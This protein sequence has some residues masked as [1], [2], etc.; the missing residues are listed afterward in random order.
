MVCAFLGCLTITVTESHVL[1]SS[2]LEV[3]GIVICSLK[4]SNCFGDL[5]HT[6]KL[7]WP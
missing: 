1:T 7:S 6:G 2:V 4:T 5:S 3:T